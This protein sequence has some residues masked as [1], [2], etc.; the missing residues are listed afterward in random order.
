MYSTFRQRGGKVLIYTGVSDPAFSPK[1]LIAYL[2]RLQQA[3]GGAAETAGFVRVFLV[4]G[5]THCRGGRS[6][7][8]FAPLSALVDWVE[9]GEAPQKLVATGKAFPGRSRPLCPYPQ[10]ARY[11]GTGSIE[12][13]AN[14]A[15][16]LP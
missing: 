7:D 1:D 10:Q 4:P 8:D 5:M 3:N 13:A 11:T 16:R 15:C 2:G 6:L 14:F 12:Q 9:K